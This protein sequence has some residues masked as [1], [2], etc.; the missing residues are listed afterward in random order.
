MKKYLCFE[1][2][3]EKYWDSYEHDHNGLPMVNYGSDIGVQYNPVTIE[4][5]ALVMYN[6]Y[7][8]DNENY[9]LQAFFSAVDWLVDNIKLNS[10]G[11]AGIPYKFDLPRYDLYSPWYSGMEIGQ[12]ISVMLRA[13]YLTGNYRFLNVASKCYLSYKVEV[14]EGGILEFDKNELPWIEEYPS[15]KNGVAS[16]VLNGYLFAIIGAIEYEAFNSE[17]SKYN[18]LLINSLKYRI[19]KYEKNFWLLYQDYNKEKDIY[20]SN[21]YMKMQYLQMLQIYELNKDDWFYRKFKQWRYWYIVNPIRLLRML[22][23]SIRNYIKKYRLE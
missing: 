1:Y 20:V 4:Q 22:P 16:F 18:L 5:Y 13:Y 15:S 23:I 10:N 6:L 9:Y 19:K 12:L 21:E 2:M 14:K 17:I 3:D 7:I 11:I 8:A